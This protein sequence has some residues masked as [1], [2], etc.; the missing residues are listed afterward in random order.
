MLNLL[1]LASLVVQELEKFGNP[2]K[3]KIITERMLQP[4][5]NKSIQEQKALLNFLKTLLKL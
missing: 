3:L 1:K 5:V 4:Y 2:L